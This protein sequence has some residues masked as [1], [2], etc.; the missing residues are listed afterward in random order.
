MAATKVADVVSPIG[1]IRNEAQ[2]REYGH[3]PTRSKLV[4]RMAAAWAL[5]GA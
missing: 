4:I 5:S 3:H 2:A 1:D